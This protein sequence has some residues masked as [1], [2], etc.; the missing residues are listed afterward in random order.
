MSQE[1][2]DVASNGK[3][4]GAAAVASG[5][6]RVSVTAVGITSMLHNRISQEMLTEIGWPPPGKGRSG[7]RPARALP[8]DEA[9]TRVHEHDGR[10]MV[11][12]VNLLA[13]LIEAGK[14]VRLDGKRQVSTGKS[15][16]LPGM[17]RLEEPYLY[18][19]VPGSTRA[20][21]WEVDLRAGR[22]AQGGIVCLCRPRFD[23]WSFRATLQIDLAQIGENAVRELVDIAG[24]RCGLGDFRPQRKG[25]CGQFRVDQW[26]TLR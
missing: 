2:L 25:L 21:Q 23:A 15:T 14:Y 16:V 8:R 3:E 22:S 17:V 24:S 19:V 7:K 5:L 10:P 13:A 1:G 4:E 9:A 12:G 26:K 11:P 18:L 6:L 20:A